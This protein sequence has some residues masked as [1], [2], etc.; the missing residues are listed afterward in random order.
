MIP[1]NDNMMTDGSQITAL[2]LAI[3]RG[4]TALDALM[5]IGVDIDYENGLYKLQSG[6]SD[7]AVMASASDVGFGI[8]RYRSAK[9]KEIRKWAFF[10]LAESGL[11]DLS[12]LE[13]HP[14]GDALLN[15]LW[16]AS[17]EGQ[18]SD[19]TIELARR[20]TLRQGP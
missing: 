1:S 5:K 10:L 9:T 19:E 15:A 14:Q 16:D 11:I 6:N 3:V 13:L 20:L 12:A 2:T 18:I 8:L 7:V 17:F 4:E